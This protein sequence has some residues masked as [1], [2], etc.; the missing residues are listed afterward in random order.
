MINYSDIQYIDRITN[1][2]KKI[3][4]YDFVKT[5]EHIYIG[6]SLP[7]LALGNKEWEYIYTKINDVDI[8]T[9]NSPMLIRDINKAFK[10]KN[11]SKTGVNLS[12]ITKYCPNKSIQVITSHF[13]DF[14][15]EVLENYDCD[16]ICVGY[17][18][19]SNKFI[20]N[21][22]FNKGYNDKNFNVF[23]ERSNEGRITKLTKRAKKFFDS[24]ITIEKEHPDVDYRPYWKNRLGITN[25]CDVET[26]PPYVQVYCNK[27][28]C[29]ICKNITEYLVCKSC[30]TKIDGYYQQNSFNEYPIQKMVVFGG[31][32]GLG[33]IIANQGVIMNINVSRT[34]RTP[35]TKT[36]FKFDLTTG[37]ISNSLMDEILNADCVVFNAYQTL[38]ND[39][40]IWTTK[41]YDF[42]EE[43]ALERF[44]IN[45]FGYIKILQQIIRKRKE[46]MTNPKNKVKDIVFV[47]MD[48]NE[49][50]FEGKLMDGKHIE[51]NMAK[52]A[53]KQIFYT[54]ANILASL[55][56]ITIFFNPNWLSYHGFSVDQIASKSEFLIPP[57]M[58]AKV[59][60]NYIKSLNIDKLYSE[61]KYIYDISFY[62]I[63]NSLDLT[64]VDLGLVVDEKQI[65]KLINLENN[66]LHND[67]E[68]DVEEDF[69][70]EE[71]EEY[72]EEEKKPKLKKKL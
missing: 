32:N 19:Y 34:T 53:W 37:K 42:N 70:D 4:I 64:K 66:I 29:C 36:Q 65:N 18:P 16:M 12:F 43:L 57:Y 3:G 60:I 8:Y 10:P 48:A 1:V 15:K 67:K 14:D 31:V 11:I 50:L 39:H 7:G 56:I 27:Y 69:E 52:T 71:E 9:T 51:L 33:N 58:C 61:K 17:H 44:K 40:S 13:N 68:E 46:F 2:L 35:K 49:S 38:E 59:L 5:Y 24:T 55:G 22:R 23:Y 62:D 63:V 54:N 21:Q 45:C 47:C 25:I 28:K 30:H 20:I 72:I 6:G 41:I 26:S